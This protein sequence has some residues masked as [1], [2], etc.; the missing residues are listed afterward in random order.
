VLERLAAEKDTRLAERDERIAGRR[1]RV[2][3]LADV[4]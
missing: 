2:R 4:E 3:V 1:R